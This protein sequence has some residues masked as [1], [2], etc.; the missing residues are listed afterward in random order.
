MTHR[1]RKAEVEILE[2]IETVEVDGKMFVNLAQLK[3]ILK[4]I[5]SD[6]P[7]PPPPPRP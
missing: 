2:S 7:P 6:V 1:I 5:F 3:L 4:G